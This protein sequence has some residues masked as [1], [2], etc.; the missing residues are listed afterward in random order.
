M[1]LKVVALKVRSLK[2]TPLKTMG[3][4]VLFGCLLLLMLVQWRPSLLLPYCV[5]HHNIHF[6]TNRP[7][8]EREEITKQI[9]RAVKLLSKSIVHSSTHTYYVYLVNSPTLYLLLGPDFSS[10]SFARTNLFN[11]VLIRRCDTGLSSCFSESPVFN[12]RP[13]WAL[14]AHEITHINLRHR[15]GFYHE[16]IMPIWKKEGYAD[17]IAQNSSYNVQEAKVLPDYVRQSH[18]YAYYQYRQAVGFALETLKMDELEFL[19]SDIDRKV[20]QVDFTDTEN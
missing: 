19:K 11:N 5:V 12:K 8:S 2:T 13:L 10:G 7:V 17:Y 18:A 16:L 14:I 9:D 4:I 15:L 3:R 6:C 20:L 1:A